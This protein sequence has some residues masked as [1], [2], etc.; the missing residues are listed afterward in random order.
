MLQ[1]IAVVRPSWV[2]SR[3]LMELVATLVL[4]LVTLAGPVA[5]TDA[6]TPHVPLASAAA[7]V[8]RAVGKVVR[9]LVVKAVRH[10]PP[11]A[12]TTP[13]APTTPNWSR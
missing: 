3:R 2:A 4:F 6:T 10:H 5:I 12:P 13:T 9:H 7:S 8:D 11:A 1:S